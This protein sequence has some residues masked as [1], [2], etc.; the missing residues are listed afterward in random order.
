MPFLNA[1]GCLCDP[2]FRRR[3]CNRCDIKKPRAAIQRG[4]LAVRQIRCSGGWQRGEEIQRIV[5]ETRQFLRSYGCSQ[6]LDSLRGPGTRTCGGEFLECCVKFFRLLIKKCVSCQRHKLA[7]IRRPWW[8]AVHGQCGSGAKVISQRI[9]KRACLRRVAGLDHHDQ[10]VRL[11]KMP[12]KNFK[13]AHRHK[14][15]RKEIEHIGIHSNATQ[16]QSSREKKH[17]QQNPPPPGKIFV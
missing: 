5:G 14:I 8:S 7:R 2:I 6:T 12:Q 11:T 4:K 1:L 17:G 15:R 13:P 10:L 9:N 16:A 3:W